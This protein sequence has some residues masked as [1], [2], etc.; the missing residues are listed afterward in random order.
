[1]S[2]SYWSTDH[3]LRQ[4]EDRFVET[5]VLAREA[6]EAI[7][8][9]S[10]READWKRLLLAVAAGDRPLNDPWG[11]A[12]LKRRNEWIWEGMV[13]EAE[14]LAAGTLAGKNQESGIKGQGD[15]RRRK[16]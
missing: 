10:A 2:I 3:P 1:M 14:A 7:V 12:I 8:T 16:I 13:A 5:G 15:A 11:R 6:V 9:A 4:L